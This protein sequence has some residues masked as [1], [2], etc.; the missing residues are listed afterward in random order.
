MFFVEVRHPSRLSHT[1]LSISV[2]YSRICGV[3]FQT[4]GF[5]A[6]GCS[7]QNAEHKFVV[8]CQLLCAAATKQGSQ[9]SDRELPRPLASMLNVEARMILCMVCIEM[10]EMQ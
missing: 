7:G 4:C 2:K 10:D 5:D 8:V 9:L 1:L 6:L 3:V